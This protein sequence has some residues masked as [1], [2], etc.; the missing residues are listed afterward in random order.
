MQPTVSAGRLSFQEKPTKM[1]WFTGLFAVV[2]AV[3][4]GSPLVLAHR[5]QRRRRLDFVKMQRIRLRA[6]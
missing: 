5:A 1:M 3:L 6:R 4:A 2:L